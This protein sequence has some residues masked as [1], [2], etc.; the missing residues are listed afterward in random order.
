MKIQ[1]KE[2]SAFIAFQNMDDEAEYIPIISDDEEEEQ[3]QS[4]P[5]ILPILPLKNTVLFPGVIIPI[6]VGRPKSLKLVK[7]VYQKNKILGVVAQ[8]DTSIEEPSLGDIYKVGSVAQILK[9]LE[10]PDGSTS[11]IIQGKKKFEIAEIVSEKPYFTARIQI[12][13]EILLDKPD[14]LQAIVASLKDIS[15]KIIRLSSNIPPEATF[16]VK[17]IESSS[18]LINFLSSNNDMAIQ[19]KQKLLEINN[20]RE[21]GIRLLEYLTKEVQMLEL[22]N[23]IQLKVK[24][25]LDQQQR[26]FLLHQQMKMIQDELGGSPVDQE[27]EGFLARAKKKKWPDEVREVFKKEADKLQRL[28]PASAEY[29]VQ[30][31]YM[32]TLIDLPWNHFT[33]DN[34]DLKRAVRILDRDHYGLENVKDRIL[35]HLA[36][37]K[38]KGDMKAPILC[39][40]GPPGVG[41]TSLG[42]SVASA[43]N[44]KY[45]RM[46]LGGLHDESEIRGHRKTYIGAM[47]GRIIQN[48]KKA[49][50]S[51]PVFVLDEIDKTGRDFHGDPESA[52]LEVL[53]PEQNNAFHDNYLGLDY[54][55]SKVMFI[56]TANTTAS[57]NPALL[58]RMEVI[59]ISG[60][61]VE[62]KAEI[63]RKHLLPKQ[64]N[65][66]GI[67]KKDVKF[68]KGSIEHLIEFYTR[69]SGVRQ[70]DKQIAR[71]LRMLA[72]KIALGEEFPKVINVV[73]IKKILG[74]PKYSKDKYE[75]NDFAGVVTGLAWTATGGEI[76]YIESSLSK[77]K[78]N[79]TLTGN[80]G[81]VMKESAV[82]ALEY[83][84][85]HADYLG[86]NPEIFEKWNVHIHV[87]EGA[88][89]KDG[90]SAGI[91]MLTALASAFTQRKVRKRLAMTGEITLR[92]KLLAVG[93]IKEKILA[94]K[95]AGIDDIIISGEN[96]KDIDEIKDIYKEGLT[97]HYK[98]TILEVLDYAL[99]NERVEKP[100]QFESSVE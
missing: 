47:P 3:K 1:N 17:N 33:K 53:D 75:S 52:L 56:A 65:A 59:E 77:G 50:S 99:L 35:E 68:G 73:D 24:H 27:I 8:K 5:D 74:V 71:L 66:H 89:P 100:L 37:L 57:I 87:P 78:G 51:N 41:K 81:D 38:L 14:E 7:E 84:K 95:R 42:K 10:M 23:D 28:N 55:L 12:V 98:D 79:L 93:G 13:D 11:V 45:I 85:S 80:L 43:L 94:A 90:P 97:F 36:V 64:F 29:S 62:E 48:L 20:L 96:A 49:G 54:D 40:V 19:E 63:A 22:K 31:N 82:I 26:E 46:S 83:L 58:D 6:T 60:Y 44:R 34:F 30:V 18:F 61:L 21:R 9:I 15:M 39:L 88:I 4:F 69:E 76:L 16:A 70:L 67:K 91:T 92:G 25:D 72:K 32:E 86:I 2:Y